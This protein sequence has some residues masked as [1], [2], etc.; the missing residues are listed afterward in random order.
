MNYPPG[1]GGGVTVRLVH[2]AERVRAPARRRS[3]PRSARPGSAKRVTAWII[4][5]IILATA[6]FALLDLFLLTSSVHH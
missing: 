1:A 2:P 3:A 5:S 4:R 6:V